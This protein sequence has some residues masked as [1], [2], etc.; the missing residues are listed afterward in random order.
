MLWNTGPSLSWTVEC[1][2]GIFFRIC[3]PSEPGGEKVLGIGEV[4]KETVVPLNSA[5][6]PSGS[7]Q[8]AALECIL[9]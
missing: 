2:A 1:F 3:F 7:R 9:L 8:Q 4:G 5:F 6:S